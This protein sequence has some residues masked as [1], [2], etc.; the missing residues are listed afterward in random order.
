MRKVKVT[1]AEATAPAEDVL[2]LNIFSRR[3]HESFK[4]H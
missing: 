1:G 4:E 3:K 2:N